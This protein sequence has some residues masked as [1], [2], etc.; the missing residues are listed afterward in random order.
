MFSDEGKKA[1]A[2][3]FKL[4]SLRDHSRRELR[5]KLLHKGFSNSAIEKTIEN[6]EELGYLDD[7]KFGKD[8]VRYCQ[9]IRN[10]GISAIRAEL[11]KK[12]I[13]GYSAD[14]ALQEYSEELEKEKTIEITR[15]K[16]EQ[17]KSKEQVYHYLSRK[18]Y[19]L[20]TIFDAIKEVYPIKGE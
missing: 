4:L 9:V 10:L 11:F 1:L 12:G 2:R 7:Q 17:G 5:D 18:G 20:D 16:F 15:K 3:A 8:Y 14:E 6:L 13:T 19:P